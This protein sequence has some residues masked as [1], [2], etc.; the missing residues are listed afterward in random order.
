M[1][2]KINPK[3]HQ[4]R[5]RIYCLRRSFQRI[6]QVEERFEQYKRHEKVTGLEINEGKTQI[7]AIKTDEEYKRKLE[8]IMGM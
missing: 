7:L 6:E 5:T 1:G 4:T 8:K 3:Q 2:K